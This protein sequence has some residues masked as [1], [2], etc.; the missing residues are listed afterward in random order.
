MNN[1]D[2]KITCAT[3]KYS[4]CVTRYYSPTR[5]YKYFRCKLIQAFADIDLPRGFACN[6][7]PLAKLKCET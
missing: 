5:Q 2:K 3:C 1:T 4:K 7:H 6:R